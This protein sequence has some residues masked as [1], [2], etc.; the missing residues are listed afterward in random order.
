MNKSNFALGVA[1][2]A[3]VIAVGSFLMGGKASVGAIATTD[4]DATNYS[5]VTASRGLAVGSSL[6]FQVSSTGA[7]SNTG[8]SVLDNLT[9]GVNCTLTDA[10]GG[11]YVLTD[12][13]TAACGQ[14]TFAAGGAGQ[15]VIA[16]T[17]PATSTMLL[18][19]PTA[20]QCRS[21]FYDANA[22][23]AATTT[24]M[25]KGDGHDVVAVT[26]DNDVIDG[27]EFAQI[28]MCRQTDGDVTTFVSELLHAD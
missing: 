8:Q 13:Q 22:L 17:M 19:I 1:L 9:Q 10:N 2:V 4:G 27:A 21:Y 6:Q 11:A 28:T 3:I 18:T 25:T 12:A 23:A 15:A 14:F 5:V 20:G 24:T 26:T 16:L 7:V